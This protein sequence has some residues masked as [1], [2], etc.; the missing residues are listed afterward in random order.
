MG[1]LSSRVRNTKQRR[2]QNRNRIKRLAK[3][4]KKAH[5]ARLTPLRSEA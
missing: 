3:A 2:L 1:T 5:N 4:K